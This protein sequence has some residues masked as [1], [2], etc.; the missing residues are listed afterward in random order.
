M[1]DFTR[2]EV[3]GVLTITLTRDAKRNAVNFEI[4]DAIEAAVHDLALRDDLRVLVLTAE[5]AYFTAGMDITTLI[6][7]PG[8]GDDGVLRGSNT[9]LVYRDR[10]HHDAFDYMEMVE[11]PIVLAPQ[12]HCVG[13]GV[14]MGVSC[15]FRLASAEAT[16]SLPEI[17]NLN[18]LPASGGI[19]R[20]T[21]L[22]GP[23]WARWIAMAG[24]VVDAEQA[25]AI[26]LV[27]AV[28]PAD[29]FQEKVQEFATHLAR[30]P[31]EPLGLAKVA[32]DA[33][34]DV[35]RRTARDFDRLAQTL[36]FHSKEW[37]DSLAAFNNRPSKP[38]PE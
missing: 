32:I 14:E 23:H 29:V 37:Q 3:D 35:D 8:M 30:L 36:L 12:G 24:Q 21:R 5:G 31:R 17:P 9:R 6:P 19:S 1:A 13:V 28:Y 16:F 22:I 26:G 25:L 4:W 27:H 11:K 15:D 20:L 18:V 34:A 2:T 7:N 10:A 33:A 38:A